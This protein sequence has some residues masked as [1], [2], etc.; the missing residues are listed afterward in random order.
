[1]RFL[2]CLV[3]AL[4]ASAALGKPPQAPRPPQ[5]QLAMIA[6]PD[7]DQD[8]RGEA[9]RPADRKAGAEGAAEPGCSCGPECTCGCQ[10]GEPCTCGRPR[11]VRPVPQTYYAPPPAFFRPAPVMAFGGFGGGGFGGGRG[12]CAGGG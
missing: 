9:A 12:G 11:K 1:M 5:D 4:S 2:L 6:R 10:Q 7:V 8:P 3:M